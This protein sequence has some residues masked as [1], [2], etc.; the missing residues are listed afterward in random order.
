MPKDATQTAA[1]I[2]QTEIER[3]LDS[4][5]VQ[6]DKELYD[7]YIAQLAA[8][9]NIARLAVHTPSNSAAGAMSV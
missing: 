2:Y 9:R 8:C 6:A 5:D 1:A 7:Y 4:L 3:R